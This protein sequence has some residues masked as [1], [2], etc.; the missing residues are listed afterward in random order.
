MMLPRLYPILDVQAVRTR[1]LPVIKAAEAMLEGGAQILQW[2]CKLPPD[3]ALFQQAEQVAGLCHKFHV[4]LV[5]NDRADIAMLLE[6]GLHVGQEDLPATDARRLI[7][8][9]ALLGLSTHNEEQLVRAAGQPIDYVALGPIFSTITKENPDPEVGL[10][11]LQQWRSLTSLP[12]VAI[13]GI[14]RKNCL[15]V[16][17]SGADSVA[18]ISDLLPE[19]TTPDQIKRRIEEWR[20]LTD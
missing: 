7:G 2:R 20:S 4:P 6:A 8:P 18:V 11:L 1:G 3:R 13:G 15:A 5:V 14:T 16:L 9:V 12:L 19:L 17:D 10:R